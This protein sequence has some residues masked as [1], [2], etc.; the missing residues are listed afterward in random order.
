MSRASKAFAALSRGA[1]NMYKDKIFREEKAAEKDKATMDRYAA[2]LSSIDKEMSSIL[3][4]P[5]AGIDTERMDTLKVMKNALVDALE[6]GSPIPSEKLSILETYTDTP[7]GETQTEGGG[8][9][10]ESSISRWIG[11]NFSPQQLDEFQKRAP[12]F[13]KFLLTG[14]LDSLI[15]RWLNSQIDK[16]VNYENLD[17]FINHVKEHGWKQVFAQHAIPEPPE[18]NQAAALPDQSP[19]YSAPEVYYQVHGQEANIAQDPKIKAGLINM[20]TRPR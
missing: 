16:Q 11:S 15:P 19:A 17:K 7:S 5:F 8:G 14:Y 2:I 1:A 6:S 20:N 18:I 10:S 4:N 12:G 3:Q 13:I 9:D